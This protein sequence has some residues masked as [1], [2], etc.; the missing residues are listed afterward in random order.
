MSSQ[1]HTKVVF[2]APP[3]TTNDLTAQQRALLVR[4]TKK[5]EQLLGSTPFLVD[6][7]SPIHISL[8][9]TLDSKGRFSTKTRRSSLDSNASSS[10]CDVSPTC[11][12]V[13]RSRSSISSF[14]SMR[15]SDSRRQRYSSSPSFISNKTSERW[16]KDTK[17]PVLRLAM[18]SLNIE[19][20]P[21]SPPPTRASFFATTPSPTSSEEEFSVQFLPDPND[22]PSPRNSLVPSTFTIPSENSLRKQ[23]MDR[24]RKKLGSGVPLQLVFP[25]DAESSDSD[26]FPSSPA[27]DCTESTLVDTTAPL[28][29]PSTGAKKPT[30]R[31]TKAPPRRRPCER[32]PCE[33]TRYSPGTTNDSDPG[34]KRVKERLSF[35]VESPDEHG[36]GCPEG[37]GLSR[38]SSKMSDSI[39]EFKSDCG[40]A[41]NMWGTRKGSEGWAP[42]TPPKD[43]V[44]L[45]SPMQ[46]LS[47]EVRRRPLSYRKPVPSILTDF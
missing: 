28:P 41:V 22:L 33:D 31:I 1:S 15:T 6:A 11:S 26:N 29:P 12:P 39:P 44:P 27:S 10:S 9:P 20:I 35:I 13:K 8:P 4:K 2:P 5:I 36:N 19:T 24:L 37:F 30:P 14:G 42:P 21:A 46:R 32:H 45:A 18:R 34:F 47:G 17:I 25:K 23:K 38:V 40:E 3:P 16:S 7:I 43:D